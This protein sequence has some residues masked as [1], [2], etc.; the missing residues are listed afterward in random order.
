[1]LIWIVNPF[2]PL[3]GDPEQEGRYATLARLLVA[4]GHRVRWWTSN[5]SHR[6]KRTVD[7]GT[8]AQACHA[9]GI[10]VEFTP[11]PPYFRNVGLRR[12]WSNGLLASRFR[13]AARRSPEKPDVLVVSSP[14]PVLAAV[15][16]DVARRFNAKSVI[17]VQDLWPDAFTSLAPRALRPLLG[18]VIWALRGNVRRAARGCDAIV[19]VADAYVQ[20]L[21]RETNATKRIA[22]I[23]LGV[24]LAAFD[25]A[26]VQGRCE[27]FTKPAGA[28]WLAYTGSLNRNYDFL[29][30]L[31]A[32][33]KIGSRLGTG[34]RFFITSRGELAE[35]AQ[36]YV[37]AQQLSNVT[38]T[39]FLEFETWA[40]LLSQCDAGFNASFPEVMIFLPNK[41]FYYL[42]AGAVVL[43]T[44]PGQCSR[45]VRDAGCGLDYAAGDV[46][47]C[48]AAI[49]RLVHDVSGRQAMQKA[50]RRLAETT[51]DRAILFPK[52]AELIERLG[53]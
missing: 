48:A 7:Q 52:Y 13:E 46:D 3:P 24:D 17:D 21:F 38:L 33:A 32:A 9:S 4:R 28:V 19:G 6:F 29:T 27:R 45:I 25:A 5:F 16:V 47:S 11:A 41:I 43:N 34:L 14:P 51:Y 49:E 15:A 35:R 1:M 42:A 20:N 23:P 8:I 22:T 31:R 36:A 10:E 37:R 50:A 39:G 30:I 12:V 44:I 53:T 2:D 18:P 26:A 40:Y